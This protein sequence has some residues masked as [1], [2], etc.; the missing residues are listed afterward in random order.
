M[1]LSTNY[2]NALT[3]Y[4]VNGFN[5]SIPFMPMMITPLFLS[6]AMFICCPL[7]S[8]LLSRGCGDGIMV[9]GLV[10]VNPIGQAFTWRR[11]GELS[12]PANS[13]FHASWLVLA[14]S[15]RVHLY[16]LLPTLFLLSCYSW[17]VMLCPYTHTS[18][19]SWTMTCE[20]MS[21]SSCSFICVACGLRACVVGPVW[22]LWMLPLTYVEYCTVTVLCLNVLWSVCEGSS[23]EGGQPIPTTSY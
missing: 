6:V 19:T 10:M 5:S 15:L 4:L 14:I 20:C 16:L 3:H 9:R 2:P 18:R 1:N 13:R 22:P 11:G 17:T 21:S 8:D 7:R 12:K 23:G